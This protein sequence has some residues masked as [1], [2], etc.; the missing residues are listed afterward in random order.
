MIF[1]PLKA[2]PKLPFG[3]LNKNWIA[4][5]EKIQP[6]DKIYTFSSNW[7]EYAYENEKREGYTIIRKRKIIDFF[8]TRISKN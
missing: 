7:S 3:H 5:K 6:R 4:F 2:A 1:D 8:L